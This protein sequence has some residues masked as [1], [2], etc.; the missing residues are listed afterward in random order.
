MSLKTLLHAQLLS[1]WVKSNN[2]QL[3]DLLCFCR[4]QSIQKCKIICMLL[5][6]CNEVTKLKR[7]ILWGIKRSHFYFQLICTSFSHSFN[8]AFRSKLR[9]KVKINLL[10]HLK[11][12]AHFEHSTVQLNSL[13]QRDRTMLHVIEY[14]YLVQE[15]IPDIR[16]ITGNSFYIISRSW[17]RVPSIFTPSSTK[18][19]RTPEFENSD[20]HHD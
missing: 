2:L 17:Q 11:Y 13:S 3:L 15:H 14:S 19:L 7:T 6:T 9:R 10:A 20:I 8:V 4:V 16:L 18:K 12:V 5:W 1:A